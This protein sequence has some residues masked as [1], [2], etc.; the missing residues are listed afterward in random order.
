MV[1]ILTESERGGERARR[2]RC[3]LYDLV[4]G[5]RDRQPSAPPVQTATCLPDL[6]GE[7]R[8]AWRSGVPVPL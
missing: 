4:Q 6:S 5:T 2:K 3:L 7:T 8:P 1:D